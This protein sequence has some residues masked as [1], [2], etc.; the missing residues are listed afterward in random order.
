MRRDDE[1]DRE[2][3][4]HIDSRVRDLVSG[5]M[6]EDAARRQAQI[7][8][9]GLQQTREAVRDLSPWWLVVGVG[10]DAQYALRLARRAPLVTATALVTLALSIG[11]N[12]AVFSLVNTLMLRPLPVRDPGSLVELVSRYPGESDANHFA[13]RFYEHFR[14]HNHVFSDLIS[15]SLARVQLSADGIAPDAIEAGYVVGR[16]FPA[17]GVRPAAGRLIEPGDDQPGHAETAVVLSWTGWTNRFHHDPAAVGSH[18]TVDGRAATIVGVAERNFSGLEVGTAP[19]LWLPVAANPA[20]QQSSQPPNRQIPFKLM[21]RLKPGVTIAQ[22]QTE[23]SALDAWRVDDLA[24]A[25]GNPQWRQARIGVEPAAAGF[26]TLRQQYG[27]PL[28]AVLAIV[29]LLSLIAC[30]NVAGL[31]LARGAARQREIAVRVALGAGRR[32]VI[33]Q[34]VTEALLLSAAA[35]TLGVGVAFAATR[36]LVRIMTSGQQII[37]LPQ[38]LVVEVTPD[39]RVLLFTAGMAVATGLIFGVAPAWQTFA[40]ATTASLR[41]AGAATDTKQRRL[42][43]HALVVAQIA[44]SLVLLTAAGLLVRHLASLRNDEVGFN[45]ESVLLAALNAQGSGL[46]RDELARRYQLLLERLQTI[47]GVRSATVSG[48]TPIQGG[49]AASFAHVDGVAERP[50]DRRYVSLNWIGRRY[51]ETLGTPLLAGRDFSVDD[52]ARSRVAI[53]NQAFVRHYFGAAPVLGRHVTLDDN[54]TTYEIVGVVGDA[55]YR[56]L[57]NPPPPSVYL[58]AFQE[59]GIA[60]QFAMRTSVAPTS[61]AD[62]V[63]RAVADVV[64]AV[65]IARLTTLADQVDASVVPERLMATLSSFFAA[66]GLLLAALGVYGLLAYTVTRRTSEIGIRMALGASQ[67]DVIR[68]VVGS[69]ARLAVAGIAGGLPLALWSRRIAAALLETRASPSLAP[70]ASAAAVMAVVALLAA[71]IPARRAARVQPVDALRAE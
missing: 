21:A 25:F 49:G 13:W 48:S 46:N 57:H 64:P 40:A 12:T 62:D 52:A 18:V 63:R 39:A 28:L 51:F 67:Q 37:G 27:E 4:F 69:A 60:S 36:T 24:K 66:V 1:I 19:E 8:F 6:A 20:L 45:R 33:R 59:R 54:R 15:S 17:L 3:R 53:V 58:N 47:P 9:G 34:L 70:T 22:A 56:T 65:R 23:M 55:K 38:H 43:S 68:M 42:M 71:W 61:I 11:A 10:Q 50:E 32:R 26:T 31:L 7:E 5:G 30:T 35:T 41:P 16:F 14:D 44:V 29:A 2:L